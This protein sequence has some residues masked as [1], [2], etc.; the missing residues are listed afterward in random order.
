MIETLTKFGNS[1]INQGSRNVAV[2]CAGLEE[3]GVAKVGKLGQAG[4]GED[5]NFSLA[6]FAIERQDH[7]AVVRA[8]DCG[9]FVIGSELVERVHSANVCAEVVFV[10][11]F[12]LTAKYTASSIDFINSHIDGVLCIFTNQGTFAGDAGDNADL[13]GFGG[14]G[15]FGRSSRLR[16]SRCIRRCGRFRR[17]RGSGSCRSLR[18]SRLGAS[19][20]HGKRE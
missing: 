15:R 5:R 20:Q 12:D 17:R 13:H 19:G 8:N 1:V 9:D 6:D 3:P 2:R 16:C 11:N 14:S 4:R 7:G 18:R 10:Y